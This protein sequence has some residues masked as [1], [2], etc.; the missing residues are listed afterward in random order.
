MSSVV[1][2]DVENNLSGLKS[3][4]VIFDGI[5]RFPKKVGQSLASHRGICNHSVDDGLC[6]LPNLFLGNLRASLW[7]N[8]LGEILGVWVN[9]LGEFFFGRLPLIHR[10]HAIPTILNQ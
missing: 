6:R 2:T 3:S 9:F 4:Q 8:F 1:G 5:L 10:S 7:V